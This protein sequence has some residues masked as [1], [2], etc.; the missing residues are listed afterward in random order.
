MHVPANVANA[1][2]AD[3]DLLQSSLVLNLLLK[4]G[5]RL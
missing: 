4:C 3:L 1:I 5:S 2:L